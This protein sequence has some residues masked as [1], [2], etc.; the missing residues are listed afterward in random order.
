MEAIVI[1]PFKSCIRL[2]GP[3]D[4]L[5]VT[6]N[7]VK[8][9]CRIPRALTDDDDLLTSFIKTAEL[10]V[11]DTCQIALRTTQWKQTLSV[12]SHND[13]GYFIK[14]G[15][16]AAGDGPYITSIESITYTDSDDDEQEIDAA[17]ATLVQSMPPRLYIPF[18]YFDE[19]DYP[20]AA[21]GTPN[22]FTVTYNLAPSSI[23][24]SA[25][26]LITQLVAYWYRNRECVN[27]IPTNADQHVLPA[28]AGLIST[29]SWRCLA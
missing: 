22:L 1:D 18:T 4:S 16:I 14:F 11:C 10:L 15:R 12:P 27:L 24:A 23:P 21:I 5:P 25:T 8:D 2:S 29:L 6:L 17:E 19:S 26:T 9:H 3:P 28:F 13:S 20:L 7:L